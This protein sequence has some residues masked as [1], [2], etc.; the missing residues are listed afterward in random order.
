MNAAILK[1]YHRLPHPLR[2]AVAAARGVQLRGWRYGRNSERWVEEAIERESWSPEYWRAWQTER[3]QR[4]LHRAANE[5]PFYR[6]H[7]S[8]RRRNGDRSSP[9]YLENWPILEKESLRANP[10]AF[11]ADDRDPA[12]MLHVQTSGSTGTPLDLWWSRETAQRWYALFEARWRRWNGVTR[13]DRWANI[14]GRM[15]IPAS[16]RRP[17]FW[18]W[19]PA[20]RQLYMSSYHLAP[21]LIPAYVDALAKYRIHYLWG[22]TSSLHSVAQTILERNLDAPRMAVAIANAEPVLD[23]QRDAK[24]TARRRSSPP[25]RNVNIGVCTPGPRPAGSK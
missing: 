22:F 2:S 8:V 15:V 5:V 25:P 10:R 18:V 19:N 23:H 17:P 21:D 16:L 4:V 9:E 7:W 24:R 1:V 13:R 20:L 14:G 11:V 3:L 6:E 12:R